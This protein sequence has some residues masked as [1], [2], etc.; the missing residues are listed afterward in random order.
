MVKEVAIVYPVA[1]LS[2][3]FGGVKQF[4]KIGPNGESLIE[5]SL[6]QALSAG[7]SW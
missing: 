2:S 5:Y 1:G 7:F 6:N 3:R 4:A